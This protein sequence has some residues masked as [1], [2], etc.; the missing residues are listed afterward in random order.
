MRVVRVMPTWA[1]DSWVESWRDGA[2]DA[3]RALVA[4][5]DRLLHRRPVQGDERELR[6]DEEG[7][8]HG[9]GDA[10]EQRA[11]TRS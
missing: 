7:G 2:P 8:A 4:V 10:G 6:R 1:A 5:V 9:E 11:A 3:G